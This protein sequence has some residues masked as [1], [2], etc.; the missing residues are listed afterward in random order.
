MIKKAYQLLYQLFSNKHER[1]EPNSGYFQGLIRKK[2]AKLCCLEKGRLL[3]IGQ[4]AGLLLEKLFWANPY[5]SLYGI[6]KS[7]Y[8]CLR[9]M[10]RLKLA[11]CQNFSILLADAYEIVFKE[12]VFDKVICINFL[13]NIDSLVKIRQLLKKLVYVT[14]PTG[15]IILE[16]RNSRNFLFMFK[17]K[18]AKY[19]DD[20]L[21]GLTA[22][23]Y[24]LEDIESVL[25]SLNLKIIRKEVIGKFFGKKFAPII[26]IEAQKK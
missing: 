17:Y 9:A 12:N 14:A 26:I 25:Q 4:G 3:E 19:Y 23:C 21:Q 16:F 22:N 18:F 11:N 20:T 5:L 1:G 13:I 2:V 24:K 8:L 10:Q 15:S 7:S 6:D